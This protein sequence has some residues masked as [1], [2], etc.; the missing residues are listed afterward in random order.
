MVAIPEPRFRQVSIRPA[1]PGDAADMDRWRSEPSVRLHQPLQ[2]ATLA[3]LRTDLARQRMEDLYRGEGE[4]FQWIVLE[5]GTSVGWITLAVISWE[6]SLAEIGYALSTPHQGRGIMQAALAL[7]LP[8]LFAAAGI[9][10]I[11]ARCAVENVASQRVLERLGFV[12]EALLR[13]YF[14]L[15]GARVDNYLYALLRADYLPLPGH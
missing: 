13:S 8:E 7:L 11:E 3:E 2:E 9:E 1:L 10:R 4:R 14:E 12:R 15:R 5:R 6:H